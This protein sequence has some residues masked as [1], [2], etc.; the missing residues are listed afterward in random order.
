MPIKNAL[1]FMKEKV[2]KYEK[3]TGQKPVTYPHTP[4]V[5]TFYDIFDEVKKNYSGNL[6]DYIKCRI[7]TSSLSRKY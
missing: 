4:C 5:K 2:D 3:I 1:K 7:C 6:D